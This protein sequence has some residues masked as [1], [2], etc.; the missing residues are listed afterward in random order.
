MHYKA[1]MKPEIETM[2]KITC[3]RDA[4]YKKDQ[5]TEHVTKWE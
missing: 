4:D 2:T 5:N 3:L 1:E